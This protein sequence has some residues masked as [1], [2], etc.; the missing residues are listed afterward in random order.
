MGAYPN[1]AC[2]NCP[3]KTHC[4]TVTFRGSR[5]ELLRVKAG[6]DKSKHRL[7]DVIKF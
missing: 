5:C 4:D 2:E 1:E 7:T 3:A 6:A